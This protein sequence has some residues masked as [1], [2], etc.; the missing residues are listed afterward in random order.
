MALCCLPLPAADVAALTLSLP[1]VYL[2]LVVHADVSAQI[3]RLQS[4]LTAPAAHISA[5][6]SLLSP[7]PV[8]P[9]LCPSVSEPKRGEVS[10]PPHPR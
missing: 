9:A 1:V 4:L 3:F 5:A 10:H 6:P 2:S 7:F 8:V